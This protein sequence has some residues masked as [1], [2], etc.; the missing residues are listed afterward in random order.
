MNRRL[1]RWGRRPHTRSSRSRV[2][3]FWS[4]P[5]SACPG[6]SCAWAKKFRTCFFVRMGIAR[7]CDTCALDW[8]PAAFLGCL[9]R[10]EEILRMLS[11]R[12][13]L[14][15]GVLSFVKLGLLHQEALQLCDLDFFCGEICFHCDRTLGGCFHLS[16]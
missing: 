12:K 7:S 13:E 16:F 11:W 10:G 1:F 15:A 8:R 6:S 9:H 5:C 14:F 3:V 4:V 2:L